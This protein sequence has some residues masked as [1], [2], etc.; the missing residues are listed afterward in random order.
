MYYLNTYSN[1]NELQRDIDAYIFFYNN[2]WLQAKLNGLSP[3]EFRT[4]AA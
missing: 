3:K 2:E 1:F 4:K